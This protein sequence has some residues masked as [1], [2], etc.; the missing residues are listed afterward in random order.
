MVTAAEGSELGHSDLP[1]SS[2]LELLL[3]LGHSLLLH[4]RS[5]YT[6]CS[7]SFGLAASMLFVSDGRDRVW[8]SGLACSSSVGSFLQAPGA[9][10]LPARGG[11][12]G[13]FRTGGQKF[14]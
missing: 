7:E 5:S 13:C 2:P 11:G 14:P 10:V 12:S 6:T 4:P 1:R 3:P 8:L 9:C